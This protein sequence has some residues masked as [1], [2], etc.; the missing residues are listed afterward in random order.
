MLAVYFIVYKIVWN[1]FHKIDYTL[2]QRCW[3][4]IFYTKICRKDL[5]KTNFDIKIDGKILSY[6]EHLP[7][8]ADWVKLYILIHKPYEI[9]YNLI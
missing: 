5:D 2:T 9:N 4:H 8:T 7:Y 1:K 6:W 3:K